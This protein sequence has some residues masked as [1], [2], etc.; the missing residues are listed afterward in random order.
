MNFGHL[1][2]DDYRHLFL[3]KKLLHQLIVSF[4]VLQKLKSELCFLASKAAP[5]EIVLMC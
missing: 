1:P 5:M 3:E 2:F 4:S